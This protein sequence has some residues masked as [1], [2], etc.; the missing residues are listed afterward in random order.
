MVRWACS[1]LLPPCP[2]SRQVLRK[3]AQVAASSQEL[4]S[5]SPSERGGHGW[6]GAQWQHS[7]HLAGG[8]SGP[9]G[10]ASLLRSRHEKSLCWCWFGVGSVCLCVGVQGRGQQRRDTTLANR[11]D[12]C[13]KRKQG[14][15]VATSR[16]Y[17]ENS[18]RHF[19][20]GLSVRSAC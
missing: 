13:S 1:F 11:N 8:P 19:L 15:M 7:P 9:P 18:V 10:R 3:R 12:V 5:S 17:H 2:R 20:P 14:G 4:R 6:G 16:G